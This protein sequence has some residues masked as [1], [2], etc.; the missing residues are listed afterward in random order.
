MN[1][2]IE[3]FFNNIKHTN[4]NNLD[5]HSAIDLA[6]YYDLNE[7]SHISFVN[8]DGEEG[9]LI[10]EKALCY[11]IYFIDEESQEISKLYWSLYE[12]DALKKYE[13]IEKS[14]RI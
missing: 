9:I 10:L 14:F 8:F 5:P 13:E 12:N 3:N 11:S 6:D 7:L 4:F 1:S 2:L